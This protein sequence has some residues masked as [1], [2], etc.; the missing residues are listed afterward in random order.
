MASSTKMK[1]PKGMAVFPHLARPDTKF[2]PLGIYKTLLAIPVKEAESIL[3]ELAAVYKGH[4]GKVPAKSENTMWKMELDEETGE[5]TGRVLFKLNVK[6]VELKD[7]SIW[8][9]KPKQFD[10]KL[11]QVQENIATGSE[12]YANVEL[13]CW[14]AGGSKG[15]TLQ[16]LAIQIVKLV[17]F[18]GGIDA[19]SFGFESVKDG[20]EGD[21]TVKE[22]PVSDEEE[23]LDD[24]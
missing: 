19:S 21:M 20:F 22:E 8:D 12:I 9:R 7:G 3:K 13:Y 15:V 24:F 2:N 6:N 17:A 4:V 18:G 1:L 10:A 14:D 11:N 16:P 23:E 5:E